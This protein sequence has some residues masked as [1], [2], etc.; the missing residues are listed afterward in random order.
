MPDLDPASPASKDPE[1]QDRRVLLGNVAAVARAVAV[2]S[3]KA[4]ASQPAAS[5]P[6]RDDRRSVS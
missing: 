6:A 2:D 5:S 1:D 4:T 3:I